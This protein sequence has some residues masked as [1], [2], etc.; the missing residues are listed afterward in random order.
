M[1]MRDIAPAPSSSSQSRRTSQVAS[2][3]VYH[4]SHST[5][6][7]YSTRPTRLV[8]PGVPGDDLIPSRR[9]MSPPPGVYPTPG[10]SSTS[11][12]SGYTN[13]PESVSHG[14]V[15]ARAEE[16]VYGHERRTSGYPQPIQLPPLQFD[17]RRSAE[18]H[19]SL[20]VQP[21][22]SRTPHTPPRPP[23]TSGHSA[24]PY[25]TRHTVLPPPRHSQQSPIS[26]Q[27]IPPP[28]T[29]E[30]VPQWAERPSIT[31]SDR[32]IHSSGE[33]NSLTREQHTSWTPFHV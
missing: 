22:G 15:R 30:P 5:S 16:D 14:D 19:I 7:S 25:S 3:V 28:F 33:Y 31:S 6:S 21:S 1:P 26:P 8:G 27:P 29:L 11:R 24:S 20:D 23:S 10:R 9:L 2:D 17:P 32:G 12:Y 18:R 13:Y 4:P